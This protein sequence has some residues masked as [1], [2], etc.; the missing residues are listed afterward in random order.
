MTDGLPAFDELNNIRTTLTEMLL[1]E[2]A[3]GTAP[4]P[5]IER[6]RIEDTIFELITMG[7]VYGVTVAGLDLETDLPVDAERMR[8]TANKLTAG[9]DFRKRISNH[10]DEYYRSVQE[11][12]PTEQSE[13][14]AEDLRSTQDEQAVETLINR[15]AVVAETETH[16]AINDGELDAGHEY[17]RT[18]PNVTLYKR[19]RTM[20]DDRVRD[21][22]DFLEGAIVPLNARF[23]TFDGDSALI[24]GG[25]MLPENNVNC[26]CDIELIKA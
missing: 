26:R 14:A 9:E 10:I 13:D 4:V 21:P 25:F 2:T 15:L 16:R 18:H 23:Y 7:Y 6:K 20:M 19:W 5:R 11:R 22:H 8:E 1:P 3:E 12:R 24:P 17:E